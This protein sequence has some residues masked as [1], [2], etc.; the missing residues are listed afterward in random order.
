M[1]S[2]EDEQDITSRKQ[3]MSNQKED[4]MNKN[5]VLAKQQKD[6]KTIESIPFFTDPNNRFYFKIY[7]YN[8][9]EAYIMDA[10][11]WGNIG[12]W[13]NHSCSPNLFVQ[14][15]FIDTYDLKFP[16]I[17]F[18]SSQAIKAGTELCCKII[19]FFN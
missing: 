18:F 17:A 7:L 9:Q 8:P 14:N 10:K 11:A 13:F 15:V 3:H 16:W 4:E 12:R 1:D 5:R 2:D 6:K 19:V